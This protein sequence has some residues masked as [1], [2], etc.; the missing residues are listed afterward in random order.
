MLAQECPGFVALGSR[1]SV[2]VF[3]ESLWIGAIDF[4]AVGCPSTR[5]RLYCFHPQ[6]VGAC[7]HGAGPSLQPWDP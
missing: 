5:G 1:A 7:C 4:M 6:A 2:F 3:S